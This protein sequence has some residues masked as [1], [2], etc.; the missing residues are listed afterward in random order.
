[1]CVDALREGFQKGMQY[2]AICAAQAEKLAFNT[3]TRKMAVRD[4]VQQYEM[5]QGQCQSL[6]YVAKNKIPASPEKVQAGT[7]NKGADLSPPVDGTLAPSPLKDGELLRSHANAPSAD[8]AR[9]PASLSARASAPFVAS[10]RLPATLSAPASAPTIAFTR[11]SAIPSA[12]TS[13]PAIAFTVPTAINALPAP[14]DDQAAATEQVFL[15]D[16]NICSF[17]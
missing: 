5:L 16:S 6:N 2:R 11:P 4:L 1:M 8:S 17:A 14:D 7:H 15:K 12:P 3:E 9:P 13:A 10:H